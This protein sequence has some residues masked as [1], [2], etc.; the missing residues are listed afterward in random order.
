MEEI[1]ATEIMEAYNKR[2]VPE[3]IT[4][5]EVKDYLNTHAFFNLHPDV[6][7]AIMRQTLKKNKDD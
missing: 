5:K 2:Y 6:A 1:K 7:A 3:T 4:L